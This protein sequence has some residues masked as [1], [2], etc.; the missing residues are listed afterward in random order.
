MHAKRKAS[1]LLSL[2]AGEEFIEQ[3]QK[4]VILEKENIRKRVRKE[5]KKE[6]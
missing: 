1:F 5:K 4:A 2:E 6:S 3:K